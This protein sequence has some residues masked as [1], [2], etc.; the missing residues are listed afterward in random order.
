MR[1]ALNQELN[2]ALVDAL[3]EADHDPSVYAV[4]ITGAG[5][6]FCAGA[7]LKDARDL[8][9]QGIPFHGPLHNSGAASWRS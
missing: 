5:T 2:D 1:N 6:A 8:A 7:D 9:D 4:A 3:I